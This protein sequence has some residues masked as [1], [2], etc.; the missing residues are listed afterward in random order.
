[1]VRSVFADGQNVR[2]CIPLRKFYICSSPLGTHHPK[3]HIN[4]M[5]TRD[6]WIDSSIHAIPPQGWIGVSARNIMI[7]GL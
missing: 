6:G 3:Y 2:P 4:T 7:L 1:M 5:N